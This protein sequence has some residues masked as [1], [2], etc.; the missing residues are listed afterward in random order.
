MRIKQRAYFFLLFSVEA[1][2]RPTS[3]GSRTSLKNL[4]SAPQVERSLIHSSFSVGSILLASF[5]S[6]IF[7]L[8]MLANTSMSRLVKSPH[9]LP[10]T[11]MLQKQKPYNLR[12]EYF[13]VKPCYKNTDPII[14][15]ENILQ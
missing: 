15:A 3:F 4:G 5:F 7:T 2:G 11:A 9:F 8:V 14:Y 12:R 10:N 1:N 6:F 13:T